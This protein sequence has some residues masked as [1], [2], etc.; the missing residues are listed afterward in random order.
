MQALTS[1]AHAAWLCH[2]CSNT[3]WENMTKWALR[4][5]IVWLVDIVRQE[6]FKGR[7][8]CAVNL[9]FCKLQMTCLH[10]FLSLL[11]LGSQRQPWRWRYQAAGQVSLSE[12]LLRLYFVHLLAKLQDL[13][14]EGS[15][16]AQANCV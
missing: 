13:S 15:L 9:G 4:F 8:A 7:V 12:L 11:Q 10:F 1:K 6:L 14:Q 5:A 2:T 16:Y 3:S